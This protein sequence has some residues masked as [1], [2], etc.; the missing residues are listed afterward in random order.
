MAVMVIHNGTVPV[1]YAP[2]IFTLIHPTPP[3]QAK[4]KGPGRDISRLLNRLLGVHVDKQ[5]KI[6]SYF[7]LLLVGGNGCWADAVKRRG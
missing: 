6:F 2:H 4:K 3:G 5:H 1:R 7:M